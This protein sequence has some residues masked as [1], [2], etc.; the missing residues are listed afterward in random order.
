MNVYG[1]IY[2]LNG[3]FGYILYRDAISRRTER[4]KIISVS[5]TSQ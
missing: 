5:C 1:Y 2:I 4:H 3:I